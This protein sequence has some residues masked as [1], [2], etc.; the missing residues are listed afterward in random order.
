MERRP[1][2]LQQSAIPDKTLVIIQKNVYALKDFLDKNPHLF[3][4]SPG[5]TGNAR[6]AVVE[7]EA[8]KVCLHLRRPRTQFH[9]WTGGAEFCFRAIVPVNEDN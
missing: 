5:E 1:S 2:G 7:Q 6:S 9:T 8:W 4:S 3:H